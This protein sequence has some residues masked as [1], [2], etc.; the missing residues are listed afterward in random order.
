MSSLDAIKA[1]HFHNSH[2]LAQQWWLT[3][4]RNQQRAMTGTAGGAARDFDG[5]WCGSDGKEVAHIA[6]GKVTFQDGSI[7]S[8]DSRSEEAE[9]LCIVM[10]GEVYSAR[11]DQPGLLKWN[12]GDVWML[13]EASRR[14][15]EPW[16]STA[17]EASLDFAVEEESQQST[18][19][20]KYTSTGKVGSRP[21]SPGK[22]VKEAEIMVSEAGC[23]RVMQGDVFKKLG[24]D[25][26]TD[27]SETLVKE[28]GSQLFTTGRSWRGRHF[29]LWVELD[30]PSSPGWVLVHGE[31]V[32][33]S[34]PLLQK[35]E[36]GEETPLVLRV[37]PPKVFHTGA[38]HPAPPT[39]PAPPSS[40]ETGVRTPMASSGNN[41]I[42]GACSD[43]ST[44]ASSQ[45]LEEH[46][47]MGER[48]F[49]VKPSASMKEVT[50]WIIAFFDVS[51]AD[52]RICKPQGPELSLAK[53]ACD[54]GKDEFVADR[55]TVRKAGFTDGS[56]ITFE[57][58]P[59][60][61]SSKA[62]KDAQLA[63]KLARQWAEEDG[64][65]AE[66]AAAAPGIGC[67]P[68]LV[69]SANPAN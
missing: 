25:P 35:V 48:K 14:E 47:A 27:Q 4:A 50:A 12:D 2:L 1:G 36:V 29:A 49:L 13:S 38:T 28:V 15:G 53:S 17:R 40:G 18:F 55:T 30:R 56:L 65:A 54:P 20:N 62:E 19:D 37:R 5:S 41:D 63:K 34:G 9:V 69:D 10:D 67:I 7:V 31:G 46:L 64:D 61:S 6:E 32:G 21:S 52:V 23:Y 51:L 57:L 3:E 44:V 16:L 58:I 26:T 8:I 68:Q 42:T 60:I 24:A 11:L 66:A 39:T 45:D 22:K 43:E 33:M 59:T